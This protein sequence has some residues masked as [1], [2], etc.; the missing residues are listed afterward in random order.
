[1]TPHTRWPID[2]P[3]V[4]SGDINPIEIGML[5]HSQKRYWASPDGGV[6][7][8]AIRENVRGYHASVSFMDHQLE[9]LLDSL[10]SLGLTEDTI[11]VFCVDHGMNIGDH[12]MWDKRT[13][14]E[15][16]ARVPLIIRDP[17]YPET[18]GMSAPALV[19]NVDIF[20]TLIEMAGLPDPT[21]KLF[22]PLEGEARWTRQEG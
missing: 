7:I 9:R 17:D 22:P 2:T 12:G 13:L 10:D 14:F 21:D 19:E 6:G 11:I 16:N 1:M 5:P 8:D 18:F 3:P 20:P 15:T 4:A